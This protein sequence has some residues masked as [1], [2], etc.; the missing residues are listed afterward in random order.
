MFRGATAFNQD[1]V[2]GYICCDEYDV[3]VLSSHQ[4][5][6]VS[7]PETG[8]VTNMHGMFSS[9]SLTSVSLPETVL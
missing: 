5:T 3:D 6:S 8:A 4:L 9:H 7:L 2:L 1:L